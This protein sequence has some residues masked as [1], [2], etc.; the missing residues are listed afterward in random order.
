MVSTEMLTGPRLPRWVTIHEAVR[1]ARLCWTEARPAVQGAFLL[2]FF[3]GAAFTMRD[4][5]DV[6][7]LL[8]GASAWSCASVSAYLF[9]G[10]MDVDEDR[11]NGSDRPIARG[12]LAFRSAVGVT[13][14]A[15]LLALALSAPLSGLIGWVIA[16]LALGWVYSAPPLAAK[17]SS[18][19]C[20]IVVFGLG[21][22]SYAGGAAV[23]GNGLDAPGVV[24]ATAMA[25]WM[26]LVG[27][28][29]K[30]FSDAEGDRAAGRR[31][32]AATRGLRVA[33]RMAVAGAV[34][35]GAGAPATAW[36]WAPDVLPGTLPL[37]L[38]GGW[39]VVRC[40]RGRHTERSGRYARRCAYRAFMI[41]QYVANGVM[42]V[43]LA[44]SR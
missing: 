24:F 15:A 26:A 10:V 42:L 19:A 11:R 7:R 41:T 20:A 30:D 35:V 16:F 40:L 23:A 27:A 39:V 5:L 22:T 29:V 12:E 21:W 25:A 32:L 4:D 6:P 18:V 34:I 9:N 17:R 8:A 2:R 3:T 1:T 14:A 33:R 37:A 36:T 31:T 43:M 44:V 38:G 28:V 13:L